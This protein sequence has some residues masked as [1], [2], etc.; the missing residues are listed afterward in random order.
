MKQA[1]GSAQGGALTPLSRVRRTFARGDGERAR[2]DRDAEVSFAP[3]TPPFPLYREDVSLVL[4]PFEGLGGT[5]CGGSR[6]P[7]LF[8][9][10]APEG[11]E[12]H[13]TCQRR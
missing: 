1:H 4:S 3:A 8:P 10:G 5:A 2:R 12:T 11:Y 9:S 6:E 13:A 7:P